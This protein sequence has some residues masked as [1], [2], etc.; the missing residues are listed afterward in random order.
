MNEAFLAKKPLV[1]VHVLTYNH[2]KFFEDTMK[3]ILMQKTNFDFEVIIG[4]DC[5]TDG[6]SELVD[7]YAAKY[8]ELITVT[9]P[10][11]NIGPQPNSINIFKLCRGKYIAYIES[12]DYWIDPLKLQKQVDFMEENDDFAICFTNTR[13]DFFE[14]K[15]EPYL[16]NEGIQKD[17][18]TIAD[19]I[20]EKEVWFM[21]T[22][23][24]LYRSSAILPTRPWYYYTKSGDIPLAILAARSGKIKY[25]PDVTTVYRRHPWGSSSNDHKDDAVFLRN[26]IMMYQ[27]LNQD[28]AYKFNNLFKKNLGDWYYYLLNS[29]QLKNQYF[30]RLFVAIKYC[31]LKYPGI[32]NLKLVLRDHITPPI[33]LRMSRHIRRLLG[34]IN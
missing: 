21:A 27:N 32:P 22:A 29:K 5:S 13:V 17:V 15:G 23:S 20:G 25:L 10:N 18:F 6:T 24:L 12:D 3:G 1:S 14:S 16:Q 8:P 33:F 7:L 11:K 2:I 31:Y 9:R 19:L 28:T 4:D 30:I 34:L 26:R